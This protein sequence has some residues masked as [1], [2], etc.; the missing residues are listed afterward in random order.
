MSLRTFRLPE[1]L[2]PAT[3]SATIISAF[4]PARAPAGAVN[5]LFGVLRFIPGTGVCPRLGD[6]PEE[7]RHE[8]PGGQ[9]VLRVERP[10]PPPLRRRPS[11]SACFVCRRPRPPVS[12][13]HRRSLEIGDHGSEQDGP[14]RPRLQAGEHGH[15]VVRGVLGMSSRMGMSRPFGPPSTSMQERSWG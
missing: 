9:P 5:P 13:N 10:S 11:R 2:P 14:G 6:A 8:L 12:R 7:S 3:S 4:T 1:S 15:L